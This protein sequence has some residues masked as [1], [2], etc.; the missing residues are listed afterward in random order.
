MRATIPRVQG[1]RLSQPET[2]G[3]P[4][5]VGTAAWYDWLEQHPAF[6][7]VDQT[8]TFTA[9]KS[10]LRTR[11]SSWKAY[12]TRQGKPYRIPLGRSDTLSL[13]R[14]HRRLQADIFR[15][16]WLEYP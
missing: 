15:V 14:L 1:G 3:D 12:H 8:A 9:R 13:E 16:N 4:I 5:V 10:I 6:T 7:F 11:G 2:E